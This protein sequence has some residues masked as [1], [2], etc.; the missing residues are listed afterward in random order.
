MCD[1]AYQRELC[2][3]YAADEPELREREGEMC[4]RSLLAI[5]FSQNNHLATVGQTE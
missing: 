5:T 3:A 2:F 4:A 1:Y